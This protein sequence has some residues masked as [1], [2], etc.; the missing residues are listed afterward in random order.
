[1]RILGDETRQAVRHRPAQAFALALLAAAA[2]LL[3]T[4]A[5]LY[6]VA[7]AQAVSHLDVRH[8][9][10]LT[11]SLRL[12]SQPSND[13]FGRAVDALSPADLAELPPASLRRHYQTPSVSRSAAADNGAYA[14]TGQVEWLP[15][16][17]AHLTVVRGHCPRHAREILVSEADLHLPGVRVGRPVS[18]AGVTVTTGNPASVTLRVVGAYRIEPGPYW[19]LYQP[20]G[21]SG[22]PDGRAV[23]HDDWLTVADTFVTPSPSLQGIT[24][25]AIFR[26]R[27]SAAD[28]HTIVKIPAQFARFDRSVRA[29]QAE[30]EVSATSNIGDIVADIHTQQDQANRI[31]PL[32]MLQLVLL[33]LV[34]FWQVLGAAADQRRSDVALARLRGRSRRATTRLLL[35]E[36][37]P[38]VEA[39][40][41]LGAVGGVLAATLVRRLLLPAAP[42]DLP[43]TYWFALAAAAL[44]IAGLT[45]LSARTL[46][47]QP[48]DRLLRRVPPRHRWQ[49]TVLDTVLLTLASAGVV[50][51]AAGGLGRDFALAGPALVALLAGLL[52]GHLVTPAAALM[53]RRALS[54]GRVVRGLAAL[55]AARRP[56]AR[57]TITMLTLSAAFLVF[58][59][60]AWSVGVTNRQSVAEQVVGAPR[61]LTVSTLNFTDVQ[62]ALSTVDP[63]G[64]RA[65]AVTVVRP[66]GGSTAPS[67][68]AVDPR[69]FPD[70]A[71]LD[72]AARRLPWGRL[73][74]DTTPPVRVD[75]KSLAF[76]VGAANLPPDAGS[77][78]IGLRLLKSDGTTA[79]VAFGSVRHAPSG[80]ALTLRSVVPCAAG[81]TVL[82]LTVS[83][84]PGA[85]WVGSIA[86]GPIEGTDTTDWGSAASWP[87]VAPA[88]GASIRATSAT[89]SG[90][91]V[92][93]VTGGSSSFTLA[94]AWMPTT[95]PAFAAGPGTSGGSP[96]VIGVDRQ[97][98]AAHVVAHAPHL[99]TADRSSLVVDLDA[100]TRG[101]L[102]DPS[103]QVQVWLGDDGPRLDRT[104]SKALADHGVSVTGDT[105]TAAQRS[106]YD[107]SVAAW[108]LTLALVIGVIT[109]LITL[110]AMIVLAVTGWRTAARD[111]AALRLNGLAHRQLLRASLMA[112]SATVLVAVALGSAAG[113][114]ASWL[115]IDQVPLFAHQPPLTALDLTPAWG[116]IGG[117]ALAT[118]IVLVAAARL[119]ARRVAA[120]AQFERLSEA[121]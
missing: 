71:L 92:K 34:V 90:L 110:L 50:A 18:V 3:S 85:N 27:R 19:D 1:M 103:N 102:L 118:L 100:L 76:T 49:W 60:N 28:V 94:S 16:A 57:R 51:F 79:V 5:P 12:T 112:Q 6:S 81:C 105:T 104:V 67:T 101:A 84:S 58:F 7:M 10:T 89:G 66:L 31:V 21:K 11:T 69:T 45:A 39:G 62:K 30:G 29:D 63:H 44:C 24:S 35:R 73:V 46:A 56:G 77:V 4:L 116:V 109:L 74:P 15:G 96:S 26:L 95:V 59:A 111:L 82:G 41:V 91:T 2:T 40:V 83:A 97:L 75:G 87:T 121:P 52:L 53:G 61:V 106:T 23:G 36:L 47:R 48:V 8:A 20:V 22:L 25:S 107:D 114:L 88:L 98:R 99:P 37:L 42:F 65:T 13:D 108:S 14:L 68:F 113:L 120:R 115:A 64:R 17:C 117:T 119:L 93:V 78:A 32:L 33:T 43:L 38:V 70:I 9:A 80:R 72:E 55:E 86:L 54:R